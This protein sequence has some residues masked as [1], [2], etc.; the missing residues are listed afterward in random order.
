MIT[1]VW[2]AS[3]KGSLALRLTLMLAIIITPRVVDAHMSIFDPSMY[4]SMSQSSDWLSTGNPANP[5]GPNLGTID[6]WWFRGPEQR[7][8]EP[9][10]TKDLPAGGQV[11]FEISCNVAFTSFGDAT[12]ENDVACPEGWGP[13]HADPSA[14]VV[15]PSLISGC[16]LGIAD[17]EHP[18]DVTMDN[19]YIISVNQSCVHYREQYFD[20]P[21]SLPAC[22]GANCIGSVTFVSFSRSHALTHR[23]EHRRM[24]LAR[25]YG[26]RQFLHDR[27]QGLHYERDLYHHSPNQPVR[28]LLLRLGRL[29]LQPTYGRCPASLRLQYRALLI[30][31]CAN[32]VQKS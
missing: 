5:I 4:E 17:V 12:S 3:N 26:H 19:M 32:R 25:K 10:S 7:A 20:I 6:E 2:H 14:L 31:L 30:T 24:V 22:T 21:A 28:H 29:V 11:K 15:K 18:D 13:Y 8:V 23:R 27:L 9:A 16:A 1:S